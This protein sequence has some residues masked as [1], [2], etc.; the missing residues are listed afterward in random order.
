MEMGTKCQEGGS[1]SC[2]ERLGDSDKDSTW[3][4]RKSYR[5][6]ITFELGLEIRGSIC[7][8]GRKR[9]RV[10]PGQ[11]G[12]RGDAHMEIIWGSELDWSLLPRAPHL[13]Y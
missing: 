11:A 13:L 3:W 5:Q 1:Q 4:D 2:V 12:C 9:G 10:P 7:V 8:V 6:Q